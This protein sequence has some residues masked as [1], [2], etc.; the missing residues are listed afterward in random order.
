[1]EAQD[2][3]L[4]GAQVANKRK[5]SKRD[6]HEEEEDRKNFR[7]LETMRDLESIMAKSPRES[8]EEFAVGPTKA[9]KTYVLATKPPYAKNIQTSKLK[10]ATQTQSEINPSNLNFIRRDE[11]EEMNNEFSPES[12]GKNTV[13]KT[14]LFDS[15]KVPELKAECAKRKLKIGGVKAELIRRLIE[16]ED[17]NVITIDE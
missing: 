14:V 11:D 9:K 1:V 5:Q 12:K 8:D 13:S 17:V 15:L 7:K 3:L 2:F 16:Y 10:F 6:L 4:L